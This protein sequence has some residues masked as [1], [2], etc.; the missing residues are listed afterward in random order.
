MRLGFFSRF[1]GTGFLRDKAGTAA[2]E[3]AIVANLFFMV[4]IGM[5]VTGY[6]F[7]IKNDLENSLTT[8]ERYALIH[9]ETDE[10]LKSLIVNN[11]ST[12][13]GSNIAMVFS[14]ASNSGSNFVKVDLTYKLDIG[15]NPMGPINVKASRI[16]RT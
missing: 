2:V 7:V 6:Y 9:P 16:F 8:A 3:F 11:L 15:F 4:I 14:R 10:K 13:K 1:H 5:F 12:Y